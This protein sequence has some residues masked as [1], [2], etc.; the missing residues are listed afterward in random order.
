MLS[1]RLVRAPLFW[2]VATCLLLTGLVWL[3][4]E[5][6]SEIQLAPD[7]GASWYYWKLPQPTVWTHLSVWA[8][9]AAHQVTAWGLIF[10]AQHHLRGYVAGLRGINVVALA[11][12]LGFI[13]L[14]MVQ[15]QVFF[16]GL[17][18]DVSIYSSQGSVILLLVV[19]LLMEN[20]RRGL[21]LATLSRSQSESLPFSAAI[22]AICSVGRRSIRSGTTRWSTPPVT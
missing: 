6:L 5:R 17:A 15:T 7:Q 4:G 1:N 20:R 14:H 10:Y 18:Q 12:N 21:F 9:Y 8:C 22:T 3:L 13:V 2:C 16:D 11:A 19:V